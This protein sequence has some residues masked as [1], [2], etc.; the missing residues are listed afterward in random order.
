MANRSYKNIFA[1][2]FLQAIAM[3]F[4][5]HF[6]GSVHSIKLFK[7]KKKLYRLYFSLII[8]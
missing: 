8:H 5:L 6:Y 7:K 3:F 4:L 1:K 2:H